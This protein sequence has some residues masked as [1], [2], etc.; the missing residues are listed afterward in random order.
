MTPLSI[1]DSV[2]VEIFYYWLRLAGWIP[3]DGSILMKSQ[4][5]YISTYKKLVIGT[6]YS[7]NRWRFDQ[8]SSLFVRCVHFFLTHLQ[9][10]RFMRLPIS[11]Y[12]AL[13]ASVLIASSNYCLDG[14]HAFLAG[15]LE[16]DF[17]L[18]YDSLLVA[19]LHCVSYKLLEQLSCSSSSVLVPFVVDRPG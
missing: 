4:V 16:F 11:F 18:A 3:M 5:Q 12:C 19:R 7:S 17:S 9:Q 10:H 8:S 14:L 1:Y 2:A 13:F 15:I 6:L